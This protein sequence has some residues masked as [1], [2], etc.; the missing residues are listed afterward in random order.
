MPAAVFPGTRTGRPISEQNMSK[1]KPAYAKSPVG[2]TTVPTGNF[3]SRKPLTERLPRGTTYALTFVL[4]WIFC[5]WVY[6]PMFERAARMSFFAFDETLMRFL[7]DQA[8]GY[9]FAGGRAL[10]LI[11][12]YPLAGGLVLS[13]LLTASVALL[14]YAL[15][16]PSR[17]RWVT[18]LV[19]AALLAYFVSLGLNLFFKGEPGRIFL[20]PTLVLLVSVVVAVVRLCVGKRRS[21]A[22]PKEL[23]SCMAALILF[24][25]LTSYALLARTNERAVTRMQSLMDRQ[26]WD[27]M[28]E[29]AQG[30]DRPARCVAA[31]YAIALSQTDQLFDKLFDIYY[32]YPELDVKY[33]DTDNG[34]EAGYYIPECSFYAG[35]INTAYHESMEQMVQDGP[36]LEGLERMTRCAIINNEPELARKY[37]H[38]LAKVPGESDFVTAHTPMAA[39]AKLAEADPVMARV[40]P[41][42]P[43][44]DTFEQDYPRPVFIGYNTTLTSGRSMQALMTSIAACLYTK[45]MPNLLFRTEAL[46]GQRMPTVVEQAVALQGLKD[47]RLLRHYPQLNNLTVENVKAFLQEVAGMDRSDKAKVYQQLESTWKGFYPLYYYFENIPEENMKSRNDERH[48]QKGGVN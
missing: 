48:T 41:L 37:L 19:P 44:G 13:A 21:A 39:D 25:G 26:D 22:R 36:T 33:Y 45:Q 7:T 20:L 2:K 10:L 15:R 3:K 47:E 6:G 8:G 38:I 28:I 32:Q 9:L 42:V 46:R 16:L 11:F 30:V 23:W 24:A 29:T 12:K 14:D 35:L 27:G 5:S 4:G 43:A 31:Y 40:L 17:W 1:K 34:A 18:Q